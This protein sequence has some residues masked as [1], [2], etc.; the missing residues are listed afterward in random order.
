MHSHP[1]HAFVHLLSWGNLLHSPNASAK[2]KQACNMKQQ[3]L[4]DT[5]TTVDQ[6]E[7][8]PSLPPIGYQHTILQ[9]ACDCLAVSAQNEGCK[10]HIQ[11]AS[12]TAF[13]L[14]CNEMPQIFGSVI[15]E[16]VSPQSQCRQLVGTLQTAGAC[17]HGAKCRQLVENA[18]DH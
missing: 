6:N 14:D 4:N 9:H 11:Y 2:N 12:L 3:I 1:S 15:L 13:V 8:K 10:L 16:K 18:S 17:L 5:C 7:I